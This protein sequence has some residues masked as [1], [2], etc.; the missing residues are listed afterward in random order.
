MVNRHVISAQFQMY[1]PKPNAVSKCMY[2]K[3]DVHI[4]VFIL[5][6]FSTALRGVALL[7]RRVA[8]IAAK[9]PF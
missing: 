2:L 8:L 5:G 9:V 4:S 6:I 7:P 3:I 1:L